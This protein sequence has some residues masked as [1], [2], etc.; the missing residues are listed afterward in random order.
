MRLSTR[1]R[2]SCRA[3]IDMLVNGAERKPVPLS[4]IAERQEVSE[5]Y[6]E[7]LFI[8]LKKAGIVKSVRGV[9]GGYVLAKRPDEIS[10]GDILRLTE[11]DI[12]PVDCSKCYRKNRCICRI[13]WEILGEIIEDYVDSITFDEINRRVKALKSKKMVKAKDKNKNA[14]LIKKINVLKKERNAVVLAHNYQRNEVQEIADYLGDSLDLSRLASKLPQKIIVFSG[15]RFMAESAKVLAPEKTV[16]IPRMDAGCPM[17]DMITAEELRAMKKQYP[18]AKTVCYVN[19]YADVKA[20]CDICC[21]SAN[22]VKVV[23]SLKAKKIIFVPDRNLADYVAKQTKKK[24]IPWEGFCYVHEF[25]E[26]DEIKKL[27]KLHPKAVIVVHPET[28]PE[29]VKIADYVLS[30]NGMV[31]LAKDSKIK[32]FIIGT[33]KGLVNRLKRENPK[34]NFYLP[35]RKPLCSNMKRIQLEDIYHSLK[36]MKYEVKMDKGILKKARKSLERMI[37]I[38]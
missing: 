4:K 27:K 37:A 10:M 25:I 29:V 16:L 18:D 34:K 11:L 17:A 3:L 14:D 5:K 38:Q 9:K 15:V 19:T 1:S 26:L 2:Y 13:Y 35:K 12:S 21:T 24:I 7:Q 28:K 20:E 23:E 8:I 6:L 32:E 31:K 30:T 36:D 22:A 33:E